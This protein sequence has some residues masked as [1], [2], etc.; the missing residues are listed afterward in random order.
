MPL[1]I[2]NLVARNQG[3]RPEYQRRKAEN[4][5][6]ERILPDGTRRDL[7]DWEFFE[8]RV[9]LLFHRFEESENNKLVNFLSIS[10]VSSFE[11]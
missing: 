1:E 3:V 7:E 9:W 11:I 2:S 10:N 8:N 6:L 5:N 4:L